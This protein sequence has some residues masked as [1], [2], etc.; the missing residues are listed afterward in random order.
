MSRVRLAQLNL[1]GMVKVLLED[2]CADV[3]RSAKTMG[4]QTSGII[5]LPTKTTKYSVLRSPFVNKGAQDQFETKQHGRL[6]EVYGAGPV[7]ED[8]T[9]VVNFMRY[10]E[11]TVL[12]AHRGA[13]RARIMLFSDEKHRVKK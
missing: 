9:K 10:L 7:S 12:P 3:L 2:V 1:R 13:A 4:V 11:H 6:I 8:A 5:R